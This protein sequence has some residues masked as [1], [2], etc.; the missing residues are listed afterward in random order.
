MA[1]LNANPNV[2]A[3]LAFD[4]IQP[5]TYNLRVKEIVPFTAQSGN[6]CWRVRLEFADVSMLNKIDGTPAKNPG[7]L[8]DNSLVVSPKDKQGKLRSFVEACGKL[9]GDLDSDDLI[10]LEVQAKIGLEEYNGEQKNIV[11]RYLT[12]K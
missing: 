6:E 12:R 8:L 9:W 5:G 11:S 3:N 1:K 2:E 7:T 4:V 10:G